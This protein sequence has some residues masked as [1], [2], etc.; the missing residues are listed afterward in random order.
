[1]IAVVRSMFAGDFIVFA[2]LI[3][4][5]SE[6]S[7]GQSGAPMGHCMRSHHAELGFCAQSST[8]TEHLM[9]D[10]VSLPL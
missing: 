1:M 2:G 3:G 6:S 9:L 7:S 10:V 5:E 8:V 4:T